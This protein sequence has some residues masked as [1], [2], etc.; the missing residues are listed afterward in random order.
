MVRKNNLSSVNLYSEQAQYRKTDEYPDNLLLALGVIPSSDK[1][2]HD[3][4]AEG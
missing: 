3:Q 2:K 1:E 4:Q